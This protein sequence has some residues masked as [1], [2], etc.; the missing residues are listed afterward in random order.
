LSTWFLNRLTLYSVI[1]FLHS[2]LPPEILSLIFN[3]IHQDLK[4]Q[5]GAVL[6]GMRALSTTC[7]DWHQLASSIPALWSYID[8]MVSYE[9]GITQSHLSAVA[10]FLELSRDAP[11]SLTLEFFVSYRPPYPTT[12]LITA[13]FHLLLQNFHRWHS[14][15]CKTTFEPPSIPKRVVA[16]FLEH[17]DIKFYLAK[18]E[19]NEPQAAKYCTSLVSAAPNLRSYV[20]NGSDY[21]V[22]ANMPWAQ[23]HKFVF[24]KPGLPL[25]ALSFLDRAKSLEVF[26]FAMKRF[27]SPNSLA[28]LP[29][30]R[31]TSMI[32]SMTLA[33]WHPRDVDA[34]LSHLDTP[35]LD[36]LDLIFLGN[37]QAIVPNLHLHCSVSL[38]PFLSSASASFRLSSLGLHNLTI[39]ESEFIKCLRI[40]SPSLTDLRIRIQGFL[41]PLDV[42]SNNVLKSLTCYGSTQSEPPLCPTLE[43]LTLERCVGADDGVLSEM[44]Q[45]RRL[46][47]NRPSSSTAVTLTMLRRLDVVFT[48]HTHRADR[49]QLNELYENG[50]HGAV[51]FAPS[52]LDRYV[53]FLTFPDDT[54]VN[55]NVDG[56]NFF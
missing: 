49:K 50:L 14:I 20:N 30:F 5:K 53:V 35:N 16:L 2:D 54:S 46:V 28:E 51:K 52:K 31:S 13:I 41:P 37:S 21:N 19:K 29:P 17:I 47:V 48:V 32:R 22:P 23:L 7:R 26:C 55:F 25:D 9:Q 15:S 4:T 6:K 11:L 33:A 36:T 45:S 39:D 1:I 18:K 8:I 38:F 40:L 10:T 43:S 12:R 34:F 56:N 42:V 44:V 27:R 24:S 3:L